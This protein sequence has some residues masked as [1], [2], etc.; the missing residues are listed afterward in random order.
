MQLER[1]AFSRALAN[2]GNKIAA[3]IAM[4]AMTTRSSMSVKPL[5]RS[6]LDITAILS[7]K[8]ILKLLC[9]EEDERKLTDRATSL[10]IVS[11]Y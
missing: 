9:H 3:N 5:G 10:L 8:L 6:L 4:M 11:L 7:K 2:T 1:R